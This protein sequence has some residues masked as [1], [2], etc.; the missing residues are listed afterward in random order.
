MKTAME[1][2]LAF[3]LPTQIIHGSISVWETAKKFRSLGAA[4][5]LIVTDRL[6]E[7]ILESL[8]KS[9]ISFALFDEVEEDRVLSVSVHVSG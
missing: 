7:G 9:G 2:I 4:K 3:H 8:T 6:V 5:G 1:A